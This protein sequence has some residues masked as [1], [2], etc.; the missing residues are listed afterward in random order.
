MT[1]LAVQSEEPGPAHP[2]HPSGTNHPPVAAPSHSP[3]AFVPFVC[4]PP[5]PPISH[6]PTSAF[7]THHARGRPVLNRRHPNSSL[8]FPSAAASFAICRWTAGSR[9]RNPLPPLS[10]EN[11]PQ[12]S[13][14]RIASRMSCLRHTRKTVPSQDI[15]DEPIT[16]L[17]Q[18]R[19]PLASGGGGQTSPWDLDLRT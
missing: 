2:P 10:R 15:D 5:R 14:V 19:D 3:F 18:N 17:P 7:I 4:H 8:L 12:P 11:P 6:P 13:M 1:V 16:A 9:P